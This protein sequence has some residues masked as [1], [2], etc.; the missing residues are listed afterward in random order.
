MNH[1]RTKDVTSIFG[2]NESF[3]VWYLV[4][5]PRNKP[6]MAYSRNLAVVDDS[7]MSYMDDF[8]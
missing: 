8:H 4:S 1:K 7:W 5:Y 2:A 6:K 3:T